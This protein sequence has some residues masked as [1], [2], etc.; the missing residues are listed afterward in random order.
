[1]G[2]GLGIKPRI[3]RLWNAPEF[4]PVRRAWQTSFFTTGKVALGE[5]L[6]YDDFPLNWV[7]VDWKDADHTVNLVE[8]P[9]LPF[10]DRSK[11]LIY[12]AH[13]IEHLPAATLTTLLAECH[14]ILRPGGRIR[15]ECPD[16]EALV[17]LYRSANPHALTHFRKFRKET[18]VE[19]F[20]YDAKYLEDH[21]M[22]LG[23]ISN[24]IVPGEGVHMPVYS[25]KEIFDEKLATLDLDSF[26]DWC[27]A[28]QT[29]EQR[30]SGGHENILYF[31]KLEKLLENA[32]YTNVVRADF[33]RTTIPELKLN[34]DAR[35]SI[36]T[37][38]HRRFYSLYVEVAN[39]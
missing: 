1:M 23:E 35:Q 12:T 22:V 31:S 24:Y 8:Q 29:P 16:A 17:S 38:P 11:R 14:R 9:L 33:G 13:L 3:E 19:R 27:F 15:I 26:A 25:P 34:Q 10:K 4:A 36:R 28:L 7:H 5:R 37:K 2:L 39:G 18:I 30:K 20:G 32:G 21:L 6:T